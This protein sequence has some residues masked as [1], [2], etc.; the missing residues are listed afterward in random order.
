MWGMQVFSRNCSILNFCYAISSSYL[1]YGEATE[2]TKA[3]LSS[4]AVPTIRSQTCYTPRPAKAT[5]RTTETQVEHRE[6]QDLSREALD[7]GK[8]YW[9]KMNWHTLFE[10]VTTRYNSQ[11]VQFA[12]FQS[13]GKR[14]WDTKVLTGNMHSLTL[15]IMAQGLFSLPIFLLISSWLT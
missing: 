12:Y 6:V 13:K 2:S 15:L 5:T 14:Q 7:R 1:A 11:S 10:V 9:L 8:Q 4:S 3:W